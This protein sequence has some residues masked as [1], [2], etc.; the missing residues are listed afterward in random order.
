MREREKEGEEIEQYGGKEIT[1]WPWSRKGKLGGG[2]MVN[3]STR[4]TGV[5]LARGGG[6]ARL[7]P[8]LGL[9]RGSMRRRG[10]TEV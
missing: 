8:P 4:A 3:G 6:E 9:G 5:G 1:W 7:S 10:P 2:A